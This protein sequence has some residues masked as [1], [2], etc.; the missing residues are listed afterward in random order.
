MSQTVQITD[1]DQ[2]LEL[3]EA[4]VEE[5]G[6]GYVYNPGGDTKHCTYFETERV[7]DELVTTPSCIVGRVLARLGYTPRVIDD[8]DS[9]TSDQVEDHNAEDLVAMGI[10]AAPQVVAHILLTAQTVQDKGGT[11]GLALESARRARITYEAGLDDG[12]LAALSGSE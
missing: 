10:I 7:G 2:A 11:F 12:R 1:A 5:A 4:I 8:Y 3:L 6:E 9:V